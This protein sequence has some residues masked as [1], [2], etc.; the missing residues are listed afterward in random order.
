MN[1]TCSTTSGCDFTLNSKCVYYEGAALPYTGIVTNDSI[2]TALQKIETAISNFSGSGEA[3]WG[4]IIGDIEDQTDLIAY[5]E[6]NYAPITGS[7]QYW[8]LA[9]V[10]TLTSSATITGGSVSVAIAVGDTAITSGKFNVTPLLIKM[11]KEDASIR[12]SITIFNTGIEVNDNIAD[13]GMYYLSDYS[14]NFV[15]RSIIDKGFADIRY[16]K[17]GGISTLTDH[18]F[19]ETSTSRNIVFGSGAALIGSFVTWADDIDFRIATE[20]EVGLD[21]GTNGPGI[22]VDTTSS[23]L[24]YT[25]SFFINSK[26]D[27]SA[28]ELF[29]HYS[30]SD[31]TIINDIKLNDTGIVVE[32]DAGI[33]LIGT[34]NG[35][36]SMDG[37]LDI[38]GNTG[39]T[40][41]GPGGSGVSISGASLSVGTNTLFGAGVSL[42]ITDL[43]APAAET[44]MLVIDDTGLVS[45]QVISGGLSDGDKGD[46]TVSASG[47]T[48]TIDNDVVTYAKIQNVS[49][50][51]RFLGRITGGVGDIEELTGTQ[52]TTLL[53]N[54]TS[55]LKG[56][57]PASGGGTTNFLRAD[58]NWTTPSSGITNTAIANELMKS[59]GTNAV[60]S[61]LFSTTAGDL[62]LGSGIAGASRSITAEGSAADV[63]INIGSKGNSGTFTLTSIGGHRLIGAGKTTIGASQGAVRRLD[64][65]ENDANNAVVTY[66]VRLE[67]Q[68]TGTPSVGIGTG[69]EF[70]TETS[71]SN[72]EIGATI[73]AITTSVTST[74]ESFDLVFKTM[75]AGA[76]AVERFR[77]VSATGR[78]S[79]TGDI[80]ASGA[81]QSVTGF[82]ASN[83]SLS[84]TI[85]DATTNGITP[86]L[87]I[88]HTTSGTPANGIG[89]SMR[90][91]V[92]TSAANIE[93]GA[94]IEA[95]TT[96]VT[97]GSEDFDLVVRLMAAGAAASEKLRVKGNSGAAITLYQVNNG[98]AY[99]ITNSATDRAYDANATSIDELADVLATLIAD[100]KLTNIIA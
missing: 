65:I 50:T 60:P 37:N 24:H 46:I 77:W 75:V 20:F 100:L 18:V 71:S 82:N 99:S 68:T 94:I 5:L 84:A 79:V 69:L 54:F 49:A 76:T 81:V 7:D 88:I 6:D 9:G 55:V 33:T 45:S 44:Y 11:E 73:E 64:V 16:W 57:V 86:L 98:S 31:G 62:L 92:E 41:N 83:G 66:P 12:S 35:S 87:D 21:S 53:D 4:G 51:S 90:F 27:I 36:F 56:L 29:L 74:S 28:T 14:A 17:T 91:Q 72:N 43:A 93:V 32:S 30:K 48:W 47:A 38:T 89:V 39:L 23:N 63:S 67:H 85:D 59:D 96:D 70:V 1:V 26:V 58:G 19:I 25:H 40:L 95:V 42:T 34:G 78:L 13:K 10:S 97:G 22:L 3:V 80:V 2:Q 52:A 15:T 8:K 61:G